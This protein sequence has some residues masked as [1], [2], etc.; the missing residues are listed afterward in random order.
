MNAHCMV[1][2]QV[3][4]EI[5][6]LGIKGFMSH[7]LPAVFRQQAWAIL[8]T[9]LEMFSY[10]LHHIQPH[11]RRVAFRTVFDG[12]AFS[13]YSSC[14]MEEKPYSTMI[15]IRRVQL[16]SHLH[17]LAAVPQTNQTQLHVCMESTALKL[18]TS[19]GSGEVGISFLS[20]ITL[21]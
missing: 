6:S 21:G 12:I 4:N 16:L 1:E 7:L 14:L 19:L 3:Y 9:L 18:I 5:E 17:S 20:G 10:R 13:L 2:I 15:V 11:Y 8:H